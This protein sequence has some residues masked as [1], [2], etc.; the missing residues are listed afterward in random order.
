MNKALL[1][2]FAGAI[3]MLSQ[4]MA[5]E[6]S[7]LLKDTV[8]TQGSGSID[9]F[10]ALIQQNNPTA[11]TLENLRAENNNSLVLAVDV[12]EA[13]NG[14]EKASSQGVAVESVTLTVVSDGNTFT[15]TDFST[16][17]Q[18]L[19][20]K[21]GQTDRTLFYTLIGRTGSS[22]LTSNTGWEGTS[23]DAV[24]TIP[25]NVS[26][27]NATSVVVEITFLET[28]TSLGD[29]EAFYDFTAGPED[30]AM[31]S[32]TDA[33]TLTEE[34]P[35][36]DEAPLVITQNQ[37]GSETDSWVY[38]PSSV[39]YYVAAYEDNYPVKSD[40]DFN[41]LVVGYRVGYGMT[42]QQVTSLIV[43]GYMIARGSGYTHDWHLHIGLPDAASGTGTLNLFKPDSAEQ[44]S[45]YPQTFSLTGSFDKRLL[46]GTKSLM[47]SPSSEFANTEIDIDLIKGH[48]FSVA[49]D[50]DTPIEIS[51]ISLPP[52]DPYLYVQNT[53]Y[54]IHL[55]EYAS[56]LG[57]SVN[58]A[59]A[60]GGFKN[61]Q[62][63][64]F[65]IIIPEDWEPPLE[66]E[67]LGGVYTTFLEFV[68]SNGEQED[69]W[70]NAPAQDKIKQIGKA[71]WKWD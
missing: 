47:R 23:F 64:P 4:A 63:Y 37:I 33:A 6:Q 68:T 69:A 36:Q 60:I 58:N 44:E 57:S 53:G 26:L 13:A 56:R 5:A 2:Y 71:F 32:Q 18:S 30:L 39:E 17:T 67:D 9:L 43:Y 61:E 35:G 7:I 52:Y 42:G 31:L 34:A 51:S 25:V 54:E 12:N 38:Y 27:E 28:N 49:F 50:F 55:P 45:G 15:F 24:L 3:S 22:S 11:A 29:P 59:E 46:Q 1:M 40:Y 19:L 70:Y 66:R 62:G 41:D 16:P 10:N 48:K 21:A 14:T 20:A 65:A 8:S